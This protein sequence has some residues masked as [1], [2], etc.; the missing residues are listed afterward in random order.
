[1]RRLFLMLAVVA[2]CLAQT[3]TPPAIS[4]YYRLAGATTYPYQWLIID[5]PLSLSFDGTSPHLSFPGTAVESGCASIAGCTP[6]GTAS[7][8]DIEPGIGVL[9]VPQVS[10]SVMTLQCSSDTAVVAYRVDPP[11]AS[12]PCA[13]SSGTSYGA[14]AWAKD[15][16]YFYTCVPSGP[17]TG[18]AM[19]WARVPLQ[20][21]W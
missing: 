17:V 13:D 14:A 11:T 6:L 9:C 19:I 15:Q 21:G 20:S 10:A 18:T 5:H 8:I 7:T 1:M 12:G 3:S 2:V 4:A 16:A